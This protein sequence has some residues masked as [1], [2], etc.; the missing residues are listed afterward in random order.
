MFQDYSTFR[1]K[2]NLTFFHPISY[3][4]KNNSR[5]KFKVFFMKYIENN[6][7]THTIYIKNRNTLLLNNFHNLYKTFVYDYILQYKY[8]IHMF[9]HVQ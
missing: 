4:L 3:M 5:I 7:N 6:N 2:D 1:N 8:I 9:K